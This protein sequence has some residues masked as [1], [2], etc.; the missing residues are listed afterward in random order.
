MRE[1]ESGKPKSEKA[2]RESEKPLASPPYRSK[3]PFP[4]RLA[5]PSLEAQFEKFIDMLKNIYINIPFAET[6]SRMPLYANILKDIFL[7]KRTIEGNAT[8]TLS[9]ECSNVIKKS[10]PKLGDPG[11]FSIPCV[12]GSETIEKAMCVL[13]ASV[14]LLPLSLFKRIGIG[15]LKPTDITLKLADRCTVCPSRFIENIPVKVGGIYIPADFV[16]VDIEED[17]EVPI[18]IGRPFL[19]TARAII[20]VKGGRIVFQV[21]DEIVGFE[22]A[23]L[24]K[25]TFDFPCCMI[26]DHSVKERFLASPT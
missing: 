21:S 12:I 20:H 8:I 15:E 5:K 9:K 4:Q 19:A 13:R 1:E 11:S 22:M 23:S 3:V 16:V 26:E 2:L 7:N 18:L 17:P 14:S 6:L 24:N 25:D 10:P